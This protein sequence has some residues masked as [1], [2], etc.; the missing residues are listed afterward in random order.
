MCYIVLLTKSPCF[1]C[2]FNKLVPCLL[3]YRAYAILPYQRDALSNVI[4]LK[5]KKMAAL[6]GGLS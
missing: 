6:G 2:Q 1:G 3:L 4:D 5:I